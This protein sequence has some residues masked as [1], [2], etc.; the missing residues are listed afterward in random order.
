M[1]GRSRWVE[2][3]T[4]VLAYHVAGALLFAMYYDLAS[5]IRSLTLSFWPLAV[6]AGAYTLKI[7]Y[8]LAKW[9]VLRYPKPKSAKGQP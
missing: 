4:R 9:V 6:L 5:G 2:G 1:D 7:I 8:Q 3:W